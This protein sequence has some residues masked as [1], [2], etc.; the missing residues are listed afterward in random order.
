M[1]HLTA[2]QLADELNLS[3]GRISQYVSEGKLDGCFEGTGRQRRFDLKKVAKALGKRLD[4]GQLM[5]NGAGTQEVLEKHEPGQEAT[6][7]PRSGAGAQQ[8]P[9][10]DDDRYKMARTLK[11]EEE[12]RRL[13]KQNAVEDGAYVLASE[14]ALQSKRLIG[15]EIAEFESVMRDGARRIADELGVDF[16]EARTI[17]VKTWRAHRARRA[18]KL[19]G[20][21]AAA[22]LTDDE[23]ASDI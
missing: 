5:G 22:R 8:L 17:L 20:E 2:T 16:K 1:A 14:A 7:R 10:H 12:A 18:E 11:A 21:A 13:R 4:P 9:E 3:K 23:T 19:Q 15:Q 6:P